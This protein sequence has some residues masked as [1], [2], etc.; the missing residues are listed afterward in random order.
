MSV[1]NPISDAEID[2]AIDRLRDIVQ[3]A[4]GDQDRAYW[5][6]ERRYRRSVRRICRLAPRGGTL[7]DVGSHFL[8]QAAVLSM[9]GYKVVGIDVPEFADNPQTRARAAQFGIENHAVARMELGTF[10]AGRENG[11]DLVIF[12]EILEHITF[13]PVQFWKRIY[14]LLKIGGKLYITTPNGMSAWQIASNVKR[15]LLLEGAG[16]PVPSILQEV[17]F[18]HHWKEY[19][20]RELHDLFRGLSP[21]FV[22]HTEFYNLRPFEPWT[23]L[24]SGVRDLVRRIASGIPELRDELEATVTL[25]GRTAWI[26]APPRYH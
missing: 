5:Q 8:H 23:G 7:L 2:A 22:V 15:S 13:N 14:E 3:A 4:G 9:L 16:V 17:T 20:A 1:A 18:G 10:L 25:S 26:A 24:K 21:D 19:S 6:H 11:F 12:C